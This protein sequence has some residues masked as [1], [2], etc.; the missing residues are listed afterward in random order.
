MRQTYMGTIGDIKTLEH[1]FS[2]MAEKGWMIDKIG[3]FLHRYRAVEPCKMRFFIDIY[4]L[5]AY[6]YPENEAVKRYRSKWEDLGWTF[7]AANKQIQVFCCAQEEEQP[8]VPIDTDNKVQ[9]KIYI[10]ACLKYEFFIYIACFPIF[11][12]LFPIKN[13]AEI[14]LSDLS[15]FLTVGLLLFMVVF[16][17]S[18]GFVA[19]WL[20]RAVK[21]ARQGSPMPEVSYRLS[22]IR[23]K[24]FSLFI[25]IFFLFLLAGIILEINN[26]TPALIMLAFAFPIIG[27][28]IG[29]LMRRRINTKKRERRENIRFA[30]ICLVVLGVAVYILS[31]LMVRYA[32]SSPE[33]SLGER[34]TLTLADF[35]VETAPG[36]TYTDVSGSLAVPVNYNYWEMNTEGSV[37]THVYRSVNKTITRWLY[38]KFVNTYTTGI[39][40]E[41]ADMTHLDP[42]QANRWG[43]DEGV[44]VTM[45]GGNNILLLMKDSTI[46]SISYSFDT[47][48]PDMNTAVQ[49]IQNLWVSV[50]IFS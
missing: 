35:G 26:G 32:P 21:S 31:Y 33:Q 20:W 29:L 13:G 34:P 15:T 11:Y 41:F 12:F 24:I 43:A 5:T 42:G 8:P 50:Q 44:T 37:Q 48:R 4:P 36:S 30:V 49:A 25:V 46:L 16:I 14:F 17:W 19:S 1:H 40:G 23:G 22:R 28:C 2:L 3:V 47:T 9:A 38:N 18:F 39:F 6:D 10:K 27:V 45:S 7:A